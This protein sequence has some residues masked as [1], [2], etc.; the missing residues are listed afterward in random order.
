MSTTIDSD[1][2]R[3]LS[4]L[5]EIHNGRKWTRKDLASR[6]AIT[7]RAVSMMLTRFR[8]RYGVRLAFTAS[9]YVILD[10]GVFDLTRLNRF[11]PGRLPRVSRLR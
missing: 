10:P 4:L 7:P 6:L 2:R 1:T 8:T 11:V 3:F 5:L 9:G